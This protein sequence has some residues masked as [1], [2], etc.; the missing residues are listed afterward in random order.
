MAYESYGISPVEVAVTGACT[1]SDFAKELTPTQ[2]TILAGPKVTMHLDG[3]PH[4]V[5]SYRRVLITRDGTTE[6]D[7]NDA[8]VYS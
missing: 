1:A 4:E 7:N 2:L 3:T 8:K 5:Y 6:R